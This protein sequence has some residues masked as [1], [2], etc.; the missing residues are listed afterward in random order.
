[1]DNNKIENLVRKII[2]ASKE[3]KIDW[4][5]NPKSETAYKALLGTNTIHIIK[6]KS[7]SY[8]FMIINDTGDEIG[9]LSDSYLYDLSG[10][11]E[12][13]K[14]R[15]LRIDENLDDIESLLDSFI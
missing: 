2:K 9:N 10:L 5:K 3:K 13:A 12:L 11:Y 14:R 4:E 15:A 7:E 8:Y 1:M 6:T